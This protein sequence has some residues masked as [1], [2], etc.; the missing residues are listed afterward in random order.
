MNSAIIQT[1]I[2]KGYGAAAAVLGSV[3]SQYRP[4]NALAPIGAAIATP[5]VAFNAEDMQFKRPSKYGKP[6]WFALFDASAAQ[7]GDYLVGGE[8]AFFIAAMQLMLPVLVVSCNRTIAVS[9]P[10]QQTGI[11][12]VSYGGNTVAAETPLM[13]GWPASVLQGTKGEKSDVALPGDT[14]TP[15][16]SILLPYFTGITIMPADIITDDL[17]R[18]YVVSSPELTDL[19]WRITASMAVT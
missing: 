15:W 3:Y 9:R 19:G 1:Q 5:N 8:G 12:A 14:R 13:T 7:V 2:Y 11:G 16:W 18:R 6:T 10:Q 4:T 17:G